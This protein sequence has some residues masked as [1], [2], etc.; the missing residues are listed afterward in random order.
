MGLWRR[1]HPLYS[2]NQYGFVPQRRREHAVLLVRLQLWQ[3]REAR[4]H[5]FGIFFDE[6][7]AFPS[8][9]WEGIDETSLP[10]A[11]AEDASLLWL[12]YHRMIN[13]ISDSEDSCALLRPRVGDR[14]GDGGAA[15]RYILAADP[16][17]DAWSQVS[18]DATDRSH[19]RMQDPQ[20]AGLRL[21]AH[22]QYADDCARVGAAYTPEYFINKAQR[23]SAGLDASL[24]HL[25]IGQNTS[26]MQ[27]LAQL[28]PDGA[29]T[30]ARLAVAAKT[31][32][33]HQNMTSQA[34][35][36]GALHD[37]AGRGREE[38][39]RNL[40]QT[41]AVWCAWNSVWSST[42]IPLAWQLTIFRG[43]VQPAALK[44]LVACIL[45]ASSQRRL[46]ACQ[47]KKLRYLVRGHAEG[48]SNESIRT[49]CHIWSLQSLLRRH[50]LLFF[51]SILQLLEDHTPRRSALPAWLFGSS[52][53]GTA[54]LEQNGVPAHSANPWLHMYYSDIMYVRQQGH[55]SNMSTDCMHMLDDPEF[56]R[57]R[58][59][60]VL[61]YHATGEHLEMERAPHL[62]LPVCCLT[63]EREFTDIRGLSIH[64]TTTHLRTSPAARRMAMLCCS[65]QCP[66]CRRVFLDRR[67]LRD[68]LSQRDA[69]GKCSNPIRPSRAQ[70]QQ[71]SHL[72]CPRCFWLAPT[73]DQL[74]QHVRTFADS[75]E[76][77][78]DRTHSASQHEA[79][80]PTYLAL[81]ISP[82]PELPSP[83][84]G[85]VGHGSGSSSGTATTTTADRGTGVAQWAF[86]R[87]HAGGE[88]PGT[89]CA[90]SGSAVAAFGA[91]CSHI[92]TSAQ[93]GSFTCDS[94]PEPAHGSPSPPTLGSSPSDTPDPR[95][96]QRGTIDQ[97]HCHAGETV[98]RLGSLLHMGS[99]TLGSAGTP[100]IDATSG[101][102]TTARGARSL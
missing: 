21:P 73:F 97:E 76:C 80:T 88:P 70:P 39:A 49:R 36:L 57:T 22:V 38:F 3:A 66:W 84:H 41:S 74:L 67:S 69:R 48:Y 52:T 72:S 1:M 82:V 95:Q 98:Q 15:Q 43:V 83:A 89:P 33:M 93:R 58:F 71:P 28:T 37:S 65:N 55:L 31:A 5:A 40:V 17:L 46:E 44:G 19:L 24:A 30:R 61:S 64:T 12:R 87:A 92:R 78:L 56:R 11:P 2:A 23:W 34:T 101:I 75:P 4:V 45:P 96:Q 29:Q 18:S 54:Q 90:P 86:G 14:Q 77:M 60:S 85:A 51:R 32:G 35:H 42:R 6:A 27:I 8:T 79:A 13:A 91:H 50:R 16:A 59:E 26:K 25:Q 100:G 94:S 20:V 102:N 99:A 62:L 9:A 63:C 68:H 53:N 10:Q 47:S 7:N 81:T